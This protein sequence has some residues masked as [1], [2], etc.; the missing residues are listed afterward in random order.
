ML[1]ARPLHALVILPIDLIIQPALPTFGGSE[2]TFEF[3]VSGSATAKRDNACLQLRRAIS[4]QAE[5]ERSYLTSMLSRRQLQG[6][7]RCR[8][9]TERIRLRHPVPN[10]RAGVALAGA[11]VFPLNRDVAILQ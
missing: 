7:V 9:G 3:A 2:T 11:H 4:I 6:F 8:R 1:I 10:K 5:A